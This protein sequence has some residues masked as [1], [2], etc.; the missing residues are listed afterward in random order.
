MANQ[1]SLFDQNNENPEALTHSNQTSETV[2]LGDQDKDIAQHLEYA[3]VNYAYSVVNDRALPSVT[4]GLKPVQRKIIYAMHELGITPLGNQKKCARI[5]GDTLGKYHPHGDA[6]TYEALVRLSQEFVMR[7]QLIVGIGNFGSRDGDSA[8][9]MRYTESRLSEYSNLLLPDINQNTVDFIPNYDGSETEPKYLPAR[10][11]FILLNGASGIAVGMATNIPPHNLTEISKAAIAILKGKIKDSDSIEVKI[12]KLMEH[13]QGPDFPVHAQIISSPEEIEKVYRTGTGSIKLRAKWTIEQ[14]A[15]GQWRMIITELPYEVSAANILAKLNK[16]TDPKVPDGKKEFTAKQKQLKQI[17]ND[18]I[19]AA[20]DESGKEYAVRLIIEPKNSKVDPNALIAFLLKQTDLD[21][22]YSVNM[23][24]IGYDSRAVR[25]NLY[26]VL[27]EWCQFR[28]DHASR[29]T[30]Y[31]YDQISHRIHILEGRLIV[32]LNIDAVIKVIREADDP[33]KELMA[34][35]GLTEVQAKDIL[36]IRLRQL[37]RMEGIKIEKELNESKELQAYLRNLLDDRDSMVSLIVDEI[38]ADIKKYG[39]VRRTT[40]EHGQIYESIAPVQQDDQIAIVLS[41]NGWLRKKSGHELELSSLSFKDGDSLHTSLN[42]TTLTPVIAF[43]T[44]GRAITVPTSEISSFRGDGTPIASLI[45]VQ[46]GA[47]VAHFISSPVT[48][49]ALFSNDAGYAFISKIENIVS[50]QKAGRAFYK[51]QDDEQLLAPV[52]LKPTD[53]HVAVYSTEGKFAVIPLDQF[54]ELPGGRGVVS[55]KVGTPNKVGTIFA[56]N[57]QDT[58]IV[59]GEGKLGK[60]YAER[61]K[62]EAL[63]SFVTDRAKK[64][65]VLPYKFEVAKLSVLELENNG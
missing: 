50:K 17:S 29:R 60:Q 26:D 43:D 27:S 38:N 51:I 37:A 40:I 30:Q 54:K 59:E 31:R 44:T 4:D 42:T 47:K 45:T 22:S 24:M 65:K 48:S 19:D 39:D 21:T 6:P 3:Y 63:Q 8:G 14:L 15:R 58:I 52:I 35:F 18:L 62:G 16:L 7:Y 32:H 1:P 57:L 56:L 20:R 34:A 46:P 53:T 61:I 55:L 28:F 9:A 49:L 36:E 33:D 23:T 5:V 2:E 64:G 13:V 12:K 10:L 25:K 41:K 11:P